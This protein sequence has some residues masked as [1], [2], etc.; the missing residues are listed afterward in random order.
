MA[1]LACHGCEVGGGQVMAVTRQAWVWGMLEGGVGVCWC[2]LCAGLK[3]GC[4]PWLVQERRLLGEEMAFVSRL[5]V[6]LLMGRCLRGVR[7][8][9]R[10]SAC[11]NANGRGWGERDMNGWAAIIIIHR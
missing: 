8:T 9:L 5:G 4:F 3:V 7:E 6:A 10:L 11:E 1:V 2:G